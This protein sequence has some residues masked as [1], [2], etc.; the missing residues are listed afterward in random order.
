M[1]TVNYV[2]PAAFSSLREIWEPLG[3]GADMTAF[4]SYDWYELL[5]RQFLSG[6]FPKSDRAAYAVCYKDGTPVM[7]APFHVRRHGI[8]YKGYGTKPG[9]YLIGEWGFTDY[10]NLIYR[11]FDPAAFDRM[12]NSARKKFRLS[13]DFLRQ[14][15]EKTALAR[16]LAASGAHLLSDG[17]CV[18][19]KRRDGDYETYLK[20]L[21]K[22][23]RQ[24]LRTAVNRAVRNGVDLRIEF[25]TRLSDP[26]AQACFA[27]YRRRSLTKN[28]APKDAALAEKVTAFLNSR[29]NQTL[30]NRLLKYN[31][32]TDGLVRHPRNFIVCI[33]AGE[34]L[35]GFLYGLKETGGVIRIMI[36]CFDEDYGW[37]SPGM[38][39][40]NEA[41]KQL[42]E[43]PDFTLLD[44]TRGTEQYKY[45]LGGTEH[46]V[47]HYLLP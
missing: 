39:A 1:Y 4:Q 30:K 9:L 17:I 10:L 7:I 15:P 38:F 27:I 11:D 44:L 13:R 6:C 8:E 24:N 31:Y 47:V 37:Y 34:Q 46:K 42:Y 29:Y 5:N 23:V 33:Y 14:L 19:V 45:D 43:T 20:S 26:E 28:R 41:L 21:R 22:S 35:I 36:V 40:L 2:S 16:H 18:A 3:S 32:V 25:K 12:L